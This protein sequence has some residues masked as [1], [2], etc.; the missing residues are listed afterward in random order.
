MPA[1]CRAQK[2]EWVRNL[3]LII[4]AVGV[5]VIFFNLDIMRHGE[6]VF[7][8]SAERK[9]NFRGDLKRTN[10][11][12]KEIAR[13]LRYTKKY[14]AIFEKV[15]IEASAQ[16]DYKK[17]TASTEILFEIHITM[18]NGSTIS[19]PVR[20]TKRKNLVPAIITKLN[21]DMR[22]YKD[23]QKKGKKIKSLVNTM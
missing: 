1:R 17:I 20:R 9:L 3:F 2:N 22:A 10:Y 16:D 14:N 21:K 11:T 12:Q 18:T 8:K 23:L 19:T 5:V 7:S 15:F 6:S 13:L 4:L